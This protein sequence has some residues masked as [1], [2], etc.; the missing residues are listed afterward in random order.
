M[1]SRLL[2]RRHFAVW[3]IAAALY[4]F[5]LFSKPSL[6]SPESDPARSQD[7][8]GASSEHAH[9]ED[10]SRSVESAD[11]IVGTGDEGTPEA[12]YDIFG[13]VVANDDN[14]LEDGLV[15]SESEL[16]NENES[17]EG[18]FADDFDGSFSDESDFAEEPAQ[19]SLSEGKTPLESIGLSEDVHPIADES[20]RGNDVP[21]V[22]D[23]AEAYEPASWTDVANEYVEEAE[24][25]L[26][27]QR[28]SQSALR[29]FRFA[30]ILGHP[31]AM[32]TVG[33]LLASGDG[34]VPRDMNKAIQFFRMALSKGHPDAHASMAFLHASGVAD[35]FGVEKNSAKALLH[36]T[37]A[38]EAGSVQAQMA[39]GYRYMHGISTSKSCVAAARYY[40]R[41]AR[42]VAFDSRN[43]PSLES[44]LTSRPPLPSSLTSEVPSRMDDKALNGG[45]AV[46]AASSDNELLDYHRHL[47][48]RGNADSLTTM[49]GLQLFG[50]HGMEANEGLALPDLERAAELGHGEASGLL[51]HLALNKNNN[52]TALR[53]FQRSA[54]AQQSIGMFGLGMMYL[55]GVGVERDLVKASMYFK[56]AAER[57]HATAA[58]QLGVMHLRGEGVE[59]NRAEAFRYFQQG[60]R[61]GQL[62][63]QLNLGI[64]TLEGH[65]PVTEPDCERG[66]ALLKKV[67]EGGEWYSLMT[68][69]WDELNSGRMYGALYRSLQAANVGIEV[70][71][72]NSAIILERSAKL[73]RERTKD[74]PLDIEQGRDAENTNVHGLVVDGVGGL[75]GEAEAD[76][77]S[78]VEPLHGSPESQHWSVTR[79]YEDAI[80]LFERSFNQGHAASGLRA[81]HMAYSDVRDF[82]RAA[83][84]YAAGAKAHCSE[85][86]FSLGLMHFHGLGVRKDRELTVKY[87]EQAGRYSSEGSVP[88]VLALWLAKISWWSFDIFWNGATE[89]PGP[90]SVR[91]SRVPVANGALDVVVVGLLTALLCVVVLARRR[92]LKREEGVRVQGG[93]AGEGLQVDGLVPSD[94]DIVPDEAAER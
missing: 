49:G 20:M 50:G 22:E 93:D 39:L 9:R 73:L 12:E 38:A 10:V 14:A 17:P 15:S 87:L 69:A 5:L 52:E 31:G 66:V 82:G 34:D 29:L 61:L 35:R 70:A 30:A 76:V 23:T 37:I 25:V 51:G 46:P 43:M 7:S 13:E 77:F 56:D 53:H 67:S 8:D 58:Y 28:D 63:A 40:R 55:H 83:A 81:G 42:A 48:V 64:M 11:D 92:R 18:Q 26:L 89:T 2:Y 62:Q 45:P 6:A 71:Q 33:S 74:T 91:S 32:S 21:V 88:A 65:D 86:A 54:T 36:W 59:K 19:W 68:L 90:A 47:A 80:S 79:M 94:G 24:H 84:A 78:P 1:H 27:H 75:L 44:F 85:C 57:Q 4:V 3:A 60:S 41:A 16:D 72:W